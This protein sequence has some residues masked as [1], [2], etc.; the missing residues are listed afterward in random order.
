MEG[1]V[2]PEFLLS[3]QVPL[4]HFFT[5]FMTKEDQGMCQNNA[6]INE[7]SLCFHDIL[8]TLCHFSWGPD[9]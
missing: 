3:M 2:E 1:N 6:L 7:Q 5:I 9:S 8:W 4:L